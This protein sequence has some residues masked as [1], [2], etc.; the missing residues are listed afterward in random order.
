MALQK[1][2]ECKANGTFVNFRESVLTRILKECFGGNSK[3][4]LLATVSEESK[5][6]QFTL[7]TLRF[8]M[9]A[10]SLLNLSKPNVDPFYRAIED[11]KFKNDQMEAELE[12]L[13]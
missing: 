8:A 7:Q 13:R 9:K 11:M 12:K 3:T 5:F 4:A 10:G 1:V 2:I 6:R